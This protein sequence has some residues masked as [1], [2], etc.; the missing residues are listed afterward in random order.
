M[1]EIRNSKVCVVGGAGFLGSHLVDHLIDDRNCAV[2]VLD[3]LI[4]GHKK[5]IHP[6][7]KFEWFD[8]TG[9]EDQL[10]KIFEYHQIEYV[11]NYAAE[12]YIPVSFERPLHVFNINAFGALK[13][14]N[15]AQDAGVK[16]ILQV[17]SAEIYGAVDGLINEDSPVHPHSTYGVAKAA[18]DYAVQARWREAGTPAIAMRQFNC[19]GERETHEYVVPVII[20]Q[21]ANS[22][23]VK[24]GND[25][26]RD[27][28]YAGDAVRMAVEL[29]EKGQFGEV[30]NMGS[31]DGIKIYDLAAMT[32]KLMGYA[33]VSIVIDPKRIRPWEIWHL[34]SNNAKL[35]KTITA[36]PTVGLEGALKR[37]IDYYFENNRLWDY[38]RKL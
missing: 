5:F 2:L 37:T 38:D 3:N 31:Q 36:R 1:I 29:L 22:K 8:I 19:L 26:F 24:L 25:S 33:Q 12:P 10:R 27:F 35:Y 28:Q 16:G 32:G 6:Q 18:I 17:S 9:S 15:A 34:Q 30:Y 14:M 4:S 7:A 13:V 23:Y 11:F 20:E 21:L